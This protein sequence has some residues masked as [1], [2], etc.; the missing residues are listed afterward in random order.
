MSL[1]DTSYWRQGPV[2][3]TPAHP[4]PLAFLLTAKKISAIHRRAI[5]VVLIVMREITLIRIIT[6]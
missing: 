4:F 6:S 1:Q 2:S 3:A 5:A